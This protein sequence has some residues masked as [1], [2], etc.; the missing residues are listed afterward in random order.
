MA[1]MTKQRAK[2]F[3]ATM[4]K[5]RRFEEEVFEFYK[6]GQMAG[7][8]HLYIGEEAVAAG[9][10]AAI[11]KQDYIGS[12]HRGHGH[13][14]ARG[15]DMGKMM[16]EILGKATGYSKG[17]G[18][19]MHMASSEQTVSLAVVFRQ[20]QVQHTVQNTEEQIRLRFASL[21][22]EQRMKVLSMNVSTW[23][24]PGIFQLYILL[25]TTFMV[26]RL[27]QDVS[28]KNMILQNVPLVM[29]FRDTQL[30]EMISSRYMRQ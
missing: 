7:L 22:M 12:T 29:A 4:Y 25:K 24:P 3:Y 11:D 30:M 18:G 14:V 20:Q 9:A 28:Q 15:A 2:E 1:K 17:K 26:L 19:S 27:I 13:L 6:L 8:A 5:I 16:A 23:Q 21:V 10:C